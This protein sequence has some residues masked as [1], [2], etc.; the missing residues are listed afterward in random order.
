MRRISMLPALGADGHGARARAEEKGGPALKAARAV[1]E[2]DSPRPKSSSPSA[3]RSKAAT[4]FRRPRLA[5]AKI[6]ER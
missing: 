4:S 1:A 5:T 6:R 3:V 2:A